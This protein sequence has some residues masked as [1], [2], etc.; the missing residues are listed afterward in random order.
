[1]ALLRAKNFVICNHNRTYKTKYSRSQHGAHDINV[2]V[3]I[4]NLFEIVVACAIVR[5]YYSSLLTPRY[6]PQYLATAAIWQKSSTHLLFH[7][8]N[9]LAFCRHRTQESSCS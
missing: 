3:K 7:S 9:L 5:V 4:P 2:R 8:M 6:T 1:M